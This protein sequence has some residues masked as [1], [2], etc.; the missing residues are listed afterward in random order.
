MGL[1]DERRLDDGAERKKE[2][3]P[4]SFQT[5]S[6]PMRQRVLPALISSKAQSEREQERGRERYGREEEALIW[7]EAVKR[8]RI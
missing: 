7:G 1:G 4:Y 6:C 5:A 2:A 8:R 3:R